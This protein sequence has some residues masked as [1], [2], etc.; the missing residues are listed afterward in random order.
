MLK[1]PRRGD[2]DA[3]HILYMGQAVK[4]PPPHHL[5]AR[6]LYHLALLF[7]LQTVDYYEL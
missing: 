4:A 6:V 7:F 2:L 1:F 5:L 3:R